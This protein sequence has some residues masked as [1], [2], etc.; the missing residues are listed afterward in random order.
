M[1][2]STLVI[3][4]LVVVVVIL[5]PHIQAQ[6]FPDDFFVAY[7]KGGEIPQ[8]KVPKLIKM[9]RAEMVRERGRIRLNEREKIIKKAQ[10]RRE[11]WKMLQKKEWKRQ[12]SGFACVYSHLSH[13]G[14]SKQAKLRE[15]FRAC[16]M[17]PDCSLGRRRRSIESRSGSSL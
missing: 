6:Y 15:Y 2:T 12:C 7:D 1:K 13:T 14:K 3:L 4:L 9:D 10:S 17:D 5:I 8:L 16:T 11:L